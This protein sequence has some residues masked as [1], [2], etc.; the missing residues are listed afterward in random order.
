MMIG[1]V[2]G[3]YTEP[4]SNYYKVKFKTAANFYSLQYVYVIENAEQ[5]AVNQILDKLK[6]Q[7]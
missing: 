7:P 5:E 6:Q 4:S 2:E 3:V 1:R